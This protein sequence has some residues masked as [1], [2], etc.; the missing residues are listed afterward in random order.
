M[1]ERRLQAARL[2][3]VPTVPAVVRRAADVDALRLALVENLQ[4]EN[5][6]AIEV[7]EAY[8][9]LVDEFGLTQ[10]ELADLVGK[11]R[12]SVAN[13]LRLLA[14]PTEVRAMIQDGR[15]GE[16]HA[17]ALL[18]LTT[19]AEQIALAKRI[20]ADKLSV[21]HVEA[22]VGENTKKTT[23]TRAS[24]SKPAH[25]TFLENAISSYLSTRVSLEEKRNGK[26]RLTIEFYSHEEFERLADLMNIPL[27]R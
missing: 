17:R 25:I 6:S 7:A 20:A 15:I 12:S 26:G 23:T 19:G 14:L 24:K 2:A 4:R 11:D 3:G 21:R 27:P 5:L 22:L 13:T 18:S 8:R 1:G 9:A 16:G 10:A